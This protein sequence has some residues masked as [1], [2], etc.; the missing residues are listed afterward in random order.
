MC[1][2]GTKCS[3][4]WIVTAAIVLSN[5]HGVSQLLRSTPDRIVR[6][7]LH[8]LDPLARGSQFKTRRDGFTTPK[9]QTYLFHKRSVDHSDLLHFF[10]SEAVREIG[11]A[12]KA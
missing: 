4:R 1:D 9:E 6:L 10:S 11:T 7:Q 12:A 8:V 5:E 2:T 3:E